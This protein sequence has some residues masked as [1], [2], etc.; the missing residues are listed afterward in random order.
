MHYFSKK[1]QA[2]IFALL[3]SCNLF[4]KKA[5]ELIELFPQEEKKASRIVQPKIETAPAKTALQKKAPDYFQVPVVHQEQHKKNTAA[6]IPV[7]Q[8]TDQK[9]VA[10]KTSRTIELCNDITET[11]IT[12]Q[13]LG[14]RVPSKFS[15]SFNDEPTITLNNKKIQ[16]SQKSPMLIINQDDI[17]HVTFHY[18]FDYLGIPYRTGG[19]KVTYK[20]PSSVEK[21][22]TQFS[23]HKPEKIIIKEAELIAFHDIS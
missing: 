7:I 12:Y 22:T 1:K 17:V 13:Y 19:K 5:K 2:L 6:A 21:I 20:I 9:S 4:A 10:K 11:M 15:I 14:A 16:T 8:C 18:Q 23:W 3:L